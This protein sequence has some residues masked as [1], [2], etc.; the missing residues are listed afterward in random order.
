M[1]SPG[2]TP[3]SPLSGWARHAGSFLAHSPG[4]AAFFAGIV[5]A[6]ALAAL[7]SGLSAGGAEVGVSFQSGVALPDQQQRRAIV[8]FGDSITQRSMAPDGGWGAR[9]A[10]AYQRKVCLF[11]ARTSHSNEL[12]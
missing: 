5:A 10:D 12:D 7:A 3:A 8:L 9:L 11:R 1:A 2:A 6:A 4:L